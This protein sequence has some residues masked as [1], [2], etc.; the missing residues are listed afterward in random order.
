MKHNSESVMNTTNQNRKRTRRVILSG[1]IILSL[2]AAKEFLPPMETG[3]AVPVPEEMSA[4]AKAEAAKAAKLREVSLRLEALAKD[5]IT[6][7]QICAEL[8]RQRIE[9]ILSAAKV[10]AHTRAQTDSLPFRGYGNVAWCVGASAKDQ[11][12]GSTDMTIHTQNAL[13]PT[14]SM[15]SRVRAEIL[16]ELEA[17]QH[18]TTGMANDY[19][20]QALALRKEVQPLG[21]TLAIPD[22]A[23][24]GHSVQHVVSEATQASIS[25]ALE[26]ILIKGTISS[27]QNCIGWLVARQA[28]TLAAGAGCAVVDGPLPIGDI[29]GGIVALVGTTWTAIDVNN[30]VQAVEQLPAEIEKSILAELERFKQDS[31]G[32]IQKM[33][34]SYTEHVGSIAHK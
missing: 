27:M 14:V 9:E 30:A 15:L 7:Q 8:T 2:F 1:A 32:T 26:V 17:L 19:Q 4:E 34:T 5:S 11:V 20:A 24:I 25:V 10:E 12:F 33:N 16:F 6:H 23:G 13:A 28:G 18:A 21:I 3:I 31:L 29:V 22:F